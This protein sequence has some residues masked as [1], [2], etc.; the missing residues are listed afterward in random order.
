VGSRSLSKRGPAKD[1]RRTHRNSRKKDGIDSSLSQGVRHWMG[2][3]GEKRMKVRDG[4]AGKG[5]AFR[6]PG[7]GKR[8]A[9]GLV[10]VQAS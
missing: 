9:T 3:R 7:R 2:V 5:F 4:P 10:H 8:K 1:L 6:G